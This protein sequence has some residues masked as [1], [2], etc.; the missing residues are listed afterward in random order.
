M[1]RPFRQWLIGASTLVFAALFGVPATIWLITGLA[2]IVWLLR[3]D[4]F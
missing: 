4:P 1:S 3:T 2:I